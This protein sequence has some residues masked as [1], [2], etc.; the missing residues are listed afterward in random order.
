MDVQAK[1]EVN[2]Q[3]A[4]CVNAG[5]TATQVAPCSEPALPFDDVDEFPYLLSA[6][7]GL[8]A[9]QCVLPGSQL[10]ACRPVEVSEG[11]YRS[12]KTGKRQGICVVRETYL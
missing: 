5:V 6:A 8:V 12:G 3:A 11:S 4:A 2:T 1:S 9:A 10:T 7:D